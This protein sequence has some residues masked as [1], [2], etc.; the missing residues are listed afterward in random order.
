MKSVPPPEKIQQEKPLRSSSPS[1]S[2]IGWYTVAGY[3][4]PKR[5][6][7]ADASQFRHRSSNS[8]VVM[9]A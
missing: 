5:G 3:G 2:S 6:C 1:S 4:R 9:P 8:A 7:R